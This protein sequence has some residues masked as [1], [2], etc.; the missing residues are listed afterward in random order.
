MSS[1]L[2]T[3]SGSLSVNCGSRAASR[4]LT[5]A[6]GFVIDCCRVERPFASD[7]AESVFGEGKGTDFAKGEVGRCTSPG[8]SGKV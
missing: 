1:S 4:L 3:R 8:V 6:A 2:T 7:L 5:L